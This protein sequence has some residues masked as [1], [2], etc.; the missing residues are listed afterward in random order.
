MTDQQ[1]RI[2]T[3]RAWLATNTQSHCEAVG[4]PYSHERFVRLLNHYEH[5]VDELVAGG[6]REI[7]CFLYSPEETLENGGLSAIDVE[8][9]SSYPEGGKQ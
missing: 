3:G 9:L 2:R 5:L 4:K 1:R 6:G 7:D 8:F